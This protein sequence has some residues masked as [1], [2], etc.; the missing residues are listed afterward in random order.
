[1]LPNIN[2]SFLVACSA[3]K[4]SVIKENYLPENK[5]ALFQADKKKHLSLPA[6]S[7]AF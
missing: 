3:S 2:Y 5:I 7:K 6:F 4:R 1:V